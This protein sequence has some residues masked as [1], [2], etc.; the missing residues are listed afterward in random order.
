MSEIQKKSFAQLKK[1]L[2]IGT[3]LKVIYH[4][5]RP[6]QMGNIKTIS[7][8]QSN[9]IYT[10][11]ENDRDN[12]PIRLDLPPASLVEYIDNKMTFYES[13]KRE[14]NDAEKKFFAECKEKDLSFWGQKILAKDM[15][16]NYLL[17][18]DFYKRCDRY[19]NVV[20]DPLVLG[21]KFIEFEILNGGGAK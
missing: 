10:T 4:G 17:E 19:N 1:D 3:Q 7:K 16:L 8:I 15:G 2:K 13:G 14:L 18:G 11:C 20:F 9:A 21:E 6:E 12:R 5:T